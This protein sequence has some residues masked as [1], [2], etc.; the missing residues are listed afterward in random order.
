M[1]RL[2]LPAE[3][4]NRF[5]RFTCWTAAA[6]IA[7]LLTPAYLAQQPPKRADATAMAEVQQALGLAQQGDLNGALTLTSRLLEK[8]P[9]LLPAWKMQGM[10]LESAGRN[11]DASKSFEQGLRLSPNDPFLLFKVGMHRFESS[12]S[13]KAFAP[14]ER[15]T[16][17]F[18]RDGDGFY[19]LAQAYRSTRQLD[20]AIK[21]MQECVRLNPN[22]PSIW[23]KYG[24]MLSSAGD[25]GKGIEWLLKAQKADPSLDRVAFDL[26]AAYMDNMDYQNAA[27][28][29]RQA[30]TAD[31]RDVDARALLATAE[32]KL[33]EWN[34]AVVD[35]DRV[36]SSRSND[37]PSL[38]ELGH[39]KLELKEYQEAIDILNRLLRVDPTAFQAHLYLSRAYLGLG[40]TEEGQHQAELH[41]RTMEKLSFFRSVEGDERES[42]I[43]AQASQLLGQH[44]EA[45]ALELYR[46]HF[47]GSATSLGDP[48]VFIGKLY[49]SMDKPDDSL[50]CLKHALEIQ[51]KV[52][53]ARTWMGMLALDRKDYEA[54][55]REFNSE[56]VND[57]NDQR[58]IAEL[59]EVRYWQ[60]RWADA[61]EQIERSKTIEPELLFMLCDSYFHIGDAKNAS[62]TAE[63]LAAYGGQNGPLMQQLIALL[64]RNGQE[65][66]AER[67][68]ADLAQR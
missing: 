46:N 2:V 42:H 50:R 58:A 23:Q 38:L 17:L 65:A 47:K 62:L 28:Y 20:L 31:A 59:G 16:R 5:V 32:A 45:E 33:A 9:G 4:C 15:H 10:I 48:F 56:L 39:C 1:D 37:V 21:A 53:G 11:D 13:D 44:K 66:L 35:F 60:G 24:D 29:A 68:S 40:N 34:D 57:P 6:S 3:K 22:D 52:R 26:A 63:I 55:E 14:L 12:G 43:A 54:A 8:S 49:F 36:L 30:V 64:N 18:P 51:P 19:Y 25:R 7:L 61:A 41:H 27:A 67:L